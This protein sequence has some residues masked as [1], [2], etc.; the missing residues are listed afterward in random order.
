M[1]TGYDHVSRTV[2][3]WAPFE[4]Q[5]KGYVEHGMALSIVDRFEDSQLGF[6]VVSL[7]DEQATV[8]SLKSI[9]D[10]GMVM[11]I[12]HGA[13]GRWI[14]TGEH[15]TDDRDKEYKAHISA[16]R[17]TVGTVYE[18]PG[19]IR[20][21]GT[22][23]MVNNEFLEREVIGTFQDSI[24]VNCS[25]ESTKTDRLWRFFSD[26]GAAVYF[27]WSES[28]RIVFAP[29]PVYRLVER[30]RDGDVTALEAYSPAVD[31]YLDARWEMLG[32]GAVA[33]AKG[34]SNGDFENGLHGWQSI[35]DGRV[36]YD[37]FYISISTAD[38]RVE[39]LLFKT[40]DDI[41][42]G[43]FAQHQELDSPNYGELCGGLVSVSPEIRFDQGDVWVTDW[44]RSTFDITQFQ[45][46]VVTLTLGTTDI[47]DSVYDT[48]VLIDN[49]RGE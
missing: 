24:I 19:G 14:T 5:V 22:F 3:V 18:R 30:L 8:S 6:T 34:L 16:R 27:G 10:F 35:G 44:K 33:F 39:E 13:R 4:W 45:G 25:C 23:Y 28:V 40:V 41:A 43:F 36:I 29:G 42:S 26:N 11:L 9:T 21:G 1:Y 2:L 20:K 7:V 12:T 48:A 32:D 15:Q 49:I 38:G 46:Q 17:M 47:G 37:T 31:P